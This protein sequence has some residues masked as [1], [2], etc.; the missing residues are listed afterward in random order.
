MFEKMKGILSGKQPINEIEIKQSA[1]EKLAEFSKTAYPKEFLGYLEGKIEKGKILIED[2]IFQP[3]IANE[4]SAF[5]T[6]LWDMPITAKV[7]GSAHSHPGP[8]NH[9]SRADLHFFGKTGIV[10]IIIKMPYSIEDIALY[11]N[12]GDVLD[13]KLIE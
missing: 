6:R 1:I 8:S 10:H 3:Y 9:P 2:I 7:I 13:Y 12:N 4:N 5:S 11:D